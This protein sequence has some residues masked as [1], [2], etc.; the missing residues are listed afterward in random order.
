MAV[1]RRRLIQ[2]VAA[3]SS[4]AVFP[5]LK[6][7]AK[8]DSKR[9]RVVVIGGGFAGATAAK[10]L[11][12]WAPDLDVL[13]IEKSSYFVSCPQSNMVLSGSRT[14]QQLTHDYQSLSRQYRV[15]TLQAT[16]TSIDTE[17]HVVK[18]KDG[19]KIGYDRLIV[20]PGVDF[21]Y[22]T[23]PMLTP[24]VVNNKIP[25]AWK[26]GPQTELL[27][28][29]LKAMPQGG[30]VVMTIPPTPYRCPPGPYERACQIALF[31]KQYNPTG[32]LI[33]LDA[34]GGIV[35]KKAL[36]QNAW[37]DDYPG[38]IDYYPSNALE[39]VDVDSLSVESLFDRF[40]ADV[41]NVIPPQKAGKAAELA[42]T[43]NVDRRWCEVDFRSYE[44]TAVP[45]V[46]VIGDAVASNLPKSGHIANSQAKVCAAAVIALLKQQPVEASPKF[47]NTCYSYVDAERAGHVAAVFA[48]DAA[49]KQMSAMPGGGSTSIAT[50]MEGR[51]AQ[52]WAQNIWSDTLR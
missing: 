19:T 25:H 42:G 26:A 48:F 24:H 36:F 37:E 43:I 30:N 50:E 49:D 1:N 46:H 3:A 14:L 4:L 9:Q 13:M 27:F 5:Q 52:A 39:S 32:K 33:I 7:A 6:L 18:L 21:I 15:R 8:T 23:L 31:L 20:A 44:S 10:Y 17:K 11:K 40:Q 51:F 45:G 12:M 35:S 22:D 29:Q 41:L 16:V 47:G 28:N 34:N 38:L 2:T